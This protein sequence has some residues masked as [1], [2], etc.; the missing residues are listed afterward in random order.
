[1]KKQHLTVG[2]ADLTHF[3]QI[4]AAIGA[5][6]AIE[7]L[8]EAFKAAGDSIIRNDGLIRKYIG[9]AILFSFTDPKAAMLAAEE[10]TSGFMKQIDGLTLRFKVAL[11]TGTVMVGKIGHPSHLV[12]DVMG[13]VVN[14]AVLLLKEA[15]QSE[16]GI[17]IC[18]ETKRIVFG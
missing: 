8:Q 2:I 5:K 1:M 6:N 9:D 12:E 7:C 15:R 13:E 14:N 16:N 3:T 10:I 18:D 17:A 4:V 11:A